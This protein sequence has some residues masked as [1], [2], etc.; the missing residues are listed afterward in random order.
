MWWLPGPW[1]RH[2]LQHQHQSDFM[3]RCSNQP[4]VKVKMHCFKLDFSST[5]VRLFP[6]GPGVL[7]GGAL[8]GWTGSAGR[9]AA[10]GRE[11]Q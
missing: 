10:E 2:T 5:F 3:T 1:L 6:P 9:L 7:E 8:G 4:P 11:A